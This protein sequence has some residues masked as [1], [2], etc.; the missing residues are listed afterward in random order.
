MCVCVLARGLTKA[1]RCSAA[2]RSGEN[3]SCA[4]TSV[5]ATLIPPLP[6]PHSHSNARTPALLSP[7]P[8]PLPSL[9]QTDRRP[10]RC[11]QRCLHG[12]RVAMA[13]QRQHQHPTQTWCLRATRTVM[14]WSGKY[15]HG[16]IS[17]GSRKYLRFLAPMSADDQQPSECTPRGHLY[18]H[19][20]L[21]RTK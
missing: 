11:F 21:A 16:Y 2:S 7:P 8:P 4:T 14:L 17:A 1:L 20:G 6:T 19:V 15:P 18:N 12:G 10:R 13:A 5:T 9:I 3:R